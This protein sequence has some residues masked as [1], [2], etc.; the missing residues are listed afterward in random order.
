MIV[1]GGLLISIMITYLQT[2]PSENILVQARW[3]KKATDLAMHSKGTR[4]HFINTPVVFR[5]RQCTLRLRLALKNTP[6][7][8]LAESTEHI[9]SLEILGP[10]L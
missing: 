10:Y 8:F 4:T 2:Y 3:Q 6:Y 9:A 1:Q 5:A 7:F